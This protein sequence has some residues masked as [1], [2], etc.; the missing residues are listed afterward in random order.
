M[1][2]PEYYENV[3]LTPCEDKTIRA[4]IVLYFLGTLFSFLYITLIRS[5]L[6]PALIFSVENSTLAEL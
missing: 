1:W 2:N 5:G 3:R 6:Y 4:L